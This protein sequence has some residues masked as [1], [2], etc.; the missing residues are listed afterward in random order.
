MVPATL[1]A[2]SNRVW[3][4]LGEGLLAGLRPLLHAA[5]QDLTAARGLALC[6]A[7]SGRCLG[8]V[9]LLL[10]ACGTATAAQK[11]AEHG[12]APEAPALSGWAGSCASNVSGPV[13]HPG[14]AACAEQRMMEEADGT[15]PSRPRFLHGSDAR[16][17]CGGFARRGTNKQR[18]RKNKAH[19]HLDT[20]PPA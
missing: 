17:S 19:S 10:C 12:L 3:P 6:P 1:Q 14:S 13:A 9:L 4:R 2:V 18:T 8:P 20:Y 15:R 11:S 16:I 5:L 7:G